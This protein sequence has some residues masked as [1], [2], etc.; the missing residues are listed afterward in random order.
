ML[1]QRRNREYHLIHDLKRWTL[2]QPIETIF[3]IGANVGQT[4]SRFKRN[5]PDA[6]VEA[7][8]PVRKPFETLSRRAEGFE[9]VYCHPFAFGEYKEVKQI[10]LEQDSRHNSLSNEVSDGVT[11]DS[12]T[13]DIS[14]RTLDAFCEE[15]GIGRIDVLKTDTEGYDLAVL[16]GGDNLLS[17][18]RIVFILSE[19][20]FHPSDEKHTSFDSLNSYLHNKG[21]RIAGFYDV[22]REGAWKGK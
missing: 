1:D 6:R 12:P 8:E 20:S 2:G 19:T 7:F 15:E 16:K 3:D 10:H 17:E 14:V 4:V 13:E 21:Y 18:Q 5:F 22:E 9:G 11:S